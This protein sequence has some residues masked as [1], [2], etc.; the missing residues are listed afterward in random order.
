[1]K[2]CSVLIISLTMFLMTVVQWPVMAEE[3]AISDETSIDEAGSFSPGSE[4]KTLDA[5]IEQLKIDILDLNTVLL[6]LQE[7]LL[8]PEDSSMIVFLSIEGG[9]YFT[10]DSVKLTLDDK[11][12]TSYLYTNREVTALRKGG[13]QR[14]YMGNVKVGEHELV[15]IFT[16]SGPKT[17]DYKRAESILFE[18]EFGATYIKLIIRDDPV[19][20]Q[21][22]FIYESWR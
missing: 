6:K 2:P 22:E 12:V 5:E 14:L 17:S 4:F 19:K 1:M 7:D 15:A 20:K 3:N 10:L 16:G 9:T 8:F 11:M 18:K 21:P 13:V